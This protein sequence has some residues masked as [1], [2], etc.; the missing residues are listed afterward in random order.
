MK[1]NPRIISIVEG[2]GDK[3]AVAGLVRRILQERLYRYDISTVKSKVAGGKPKLLN[4]LENLLRYSMLEGCDAILV[5]VDAD[6]E[7]PYKEAMRVATK[8]S[9][10]NLNVPV[11]VVYAK[12]EYESWFISNLG[13]GA[14]M[15]I[16][17]SLGI[18]WDVVAP[19]VA[20]DITGAK[21]WL[22]RNMPRGRA[23]RE[24]QDQARLTYY[25]DLNL[26]HSTSR[27]FRRLCHAVEELVE[28][29]DV[30]STGVTPPA[31]PF[32]KPV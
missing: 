26:T 16:R 31:E 9:A 20:E 4:K 24:T 21:G 32:P 17:K 25:I 29:I 10:L 8:V 15:R 7:C 13:A 30:C 2:D 27:S 23:Y 19:Q 1:R 3:L 6:K 14:G 22:T 11:A 18:A 12:A 5:L 28:A